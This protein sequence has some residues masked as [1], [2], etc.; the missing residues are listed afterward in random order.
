MA[1]YSTEDIRNIALIGHGGAGKTTLA[2]AILLATGTTSRLGNVNDGSSHLDFTEEEK[3]RGCSIDSA[4]CY[5]QQEGKRLNLI[6]TPGAPDFVGPAIV[7]LAAIE[8]GVCVISAAAGIEVNTRR[9]M[10]RAKDFGLARIIVINKIDTENVNLAELL[11]AIQETF[12]RQ[13]RPVNLPTDGGKGVVDCLVGTSG[14]SDLGDVGEA[15]TALVETVAESD[16]Q[17]MEKYFD[18]GDLE[19][20]EVLAAMPAA[21]ADGS[22]VPVLFTAATEPVGVKELLSFLVAAAPSPTQGKQRVLVD[23]ETEEPIEPDADKPFVGQV[24]KVTTDPKSNIKFSLVRVHAGRLRSDTGMQVNE[25]RKAQRPGALSKMLGGEHEDVD[26]AQAG[27]IVAVAKLDLSIG[28]VLHTGRPGKI[29]VPVVPAPMF[30]LAIEPKSRSDGEKVSGALAKF[31]EE[32]PCFVAER[33]P[34]THELLIRGVG[35]LHLRTVLSRMKRHFKLEV[36][37]KPPKIP[38]R[39]TITAVA[40]E[41]EYAHKKQ[42]GGAGQYAKVVITVEPNERGGGYEFIDEI[43]GGSIDQPFRPSVDK[44]VQAQMRE[45]I[46]AGYPVVDMKVKL[47]DGKTHPVDSKDIAFQIAG[48]EALKL[49]F[50]QAKPTLLEPIVNIEITLPTSSVGDI[51]GDLASRR[52]RPQGQDT[53][54]GGMA[55]IRGQAP[56]AE[57]SDYSSRLS[58]ITGGQGS[59]TM[60][61]SHYEQVPPNV[62]QQIVEQA[63]KAKQ[64]ERE[65]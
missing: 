45:G 54:P 59:Y 9:M 14:S 26:E 50:N 60:E 43:F 25:D 8:T 38:Y 21:L 57:L 39:E 51:Q 7:S 41:V 48:R 62:Q 15:R 12:G 27:D 17:L 4:V 63:K 56:L 10:D 19:V 46:I 64:E 3:D 5:V 44:G 53:L 42:T 31:N 1:T 30:A 40:R 32:D 34:A 22:L 24:F 33:D 20:A 37:T 35:D 18:A 29:E 11:A 23:G 49:A 47:V 61:L 36:N 28:D 65:K 13:C 6:D 52:G 16:E 58:S 2:E 55:V